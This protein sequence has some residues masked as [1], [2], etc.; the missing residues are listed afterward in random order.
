MYP[1][2]NDFSTVCKE[3]KQIDP[4]TSCWFRSSIQCINKFRWKVHN[5]PRL[6]ISTATM[7]RELSPVN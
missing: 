2:A 4:K 7:S 3:I 5:G 1:K 6:I